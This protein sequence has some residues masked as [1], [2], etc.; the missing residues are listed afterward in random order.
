MNN[1]DLKTFVVNL[2]KAII[3]NEVKYHEE[4]LKTDPINIKVM[5]MFK[6]VS[7]IPTKEPVNWANQIQIY[8]NGG[9]LRLYWYDTVAHV[10]HYVTA[11]A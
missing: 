4:S 11:T 2:D 8:V 3:S 5:G 9:T 10:W 7:V 6:T 1:Q